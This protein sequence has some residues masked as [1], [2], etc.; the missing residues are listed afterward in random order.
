[1]AKDAQIAAARE[2]INLNL[3]NATAAG[4]AARTHLDAAALTAAADAMNAGQELTPAQVNI[5]ARFNSVLGAILDTAYERAEQ[6]YKNKARGL[7]ALIAIL[8][9]L[10]GGALIYRTEYPTE[11]VATYLAL[12]NDMMLALLIGL[13]ATPVAPIAKDLSGALS[14]AVHAL[15][16]ARR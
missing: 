13:V 10:A 5:L 7:A 6:A 9:S 16:R 3:N 11:S 4:Y 1:M 2:L 12:S 15:S 14:T 8:L